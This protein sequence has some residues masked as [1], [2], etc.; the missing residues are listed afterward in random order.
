MDYLAEYL[1]EM[2]KRNF[3]DAID[4]YFKLGRDLNQRDT[5]AIRRTVSGLLKLLYPDGKYDR[6]AVARCLDYALESRRRVSVGYFLQMQRLR[7][8]RPQQPH[9]LGRRR[10]ESGRLIKEWNLVVPVSL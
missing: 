2:R 1:R 5:I 7:V 4:R 8:H 9:Y 6:D 10:E 3:S